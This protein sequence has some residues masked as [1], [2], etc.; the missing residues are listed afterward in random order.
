MYISRPES[1]L[2]VEESDIIGNR[3]SQRYKIPKWNKWQVLFGVEYQHANSMLAMAESYYKGY[4]SAWLAQ[5][6]AFNDALF[7]AFQVFLAAKGAQGAIPLKDGKGVL[8]DYGNLINH[9]I[10][11]SCYPKLAMHLSAVHARRSKLP[12]AHPYDKRTGQKAT[13]LK[14]NEQREMVAHL[15]AAYIEIIRITTVICI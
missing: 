9:G 12:N 3:L 7:K 11:K 6:D 5:Q 2:M 14:A 13:V 1:S 10:F 15:A 4:R 8:N